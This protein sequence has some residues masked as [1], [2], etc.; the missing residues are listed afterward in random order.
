MRVRR[1]LTI[2]QMA[3][4]SG[5]ALVTICIFIVIQL[6]HFVQQRRDDYAQQLENVAQAVRQPLAEAVLRMDVPETKRVLNSLQPVGIL[7]RADIVLPNEFQA[8]H[9]NFPPE[10]PV[11]ALVAR[12][13]E[14][15]VQISVPLYSLERVPANPQPLAYLVLQADSY[16]M[17]Q[18]IL[19]TL[20]TMLSTYLLLA[21]IL[22]IAVS[23]C[24]NRLLVY[25]LRAMARELENVPQ[26]DLPYHQLMLPAQH[27]DDELGL[28]V[29]NYNRNQQTLAKAHT[30][31]SRLSTHNSMTE[32]PNPVLF[33]ALLEQH[34]AASMRPARFNLLVVGIE[35]LHEASGA[36]NPS[37]REA[38]LLTLAKKLRQVI[39]VDCVLAQL[40]NAEFAILAKNIEQPLH[41]MQLARRVMAAI[42]A[43]LNLQQK[44][45]LRP[46]ASIG[47]AHYPNSGESAE[48]LLR[49]ATSAM[50]SAHREGK[51]QILFFEPCLTEKTQKRLTQESEILL[52]IEQRQFALFLQ[53]QWDMQTNQV[54]GAEALLRWQLPDGQIILP[55]DVIPLAEELDV[56]VPLGNWVLEESCRIL[57][58]WQSQGITLPLAVNI[59][60]IQL[61]HKD[62]VPQLKRLLDEHQIDPHKL[63]LEITETVRIHDLDGALEL[64]RELHDLGVSIAL[65]DFGMGYASLNYL[66]RL[67]SLPIDLI[68]IDKSFIDGLPEDDAM[69]RI[70]S[71]ISEVLHLPVM[72]EGV[73]TTAQR[74]WLLQHGIRTGQGFLFAKP[75]PRKEFEAQ[76]ASVAKA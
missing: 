49:S 27:Q 9:A 23:W 26:E 58:A 55:A 17:Y 75:L 51:N 20:S 68:K 56:I 50:M 12:I 11:P 35:T 30:A 28:L 25:P 7:T 46:S 72:A 19:S 62:F 57:A 39:G 73:E 52:A 16:R 34:I 67:K 63:L 2:K 14:L 60:P 69:V 22:S 70:V 47:I 54:T 5:V 24:M 43:P 59:S 45:P 37:M 13:F 64:L 29:R 36:L 41:A 65:D 15:P 32:L 42:N 1:S 74:D 71:S 53:P 44:M 66:N 40:S 48:Q 3:A 6:F 76:F 33:A 8:L 38:L 31:M 61:Q 4:V 10:R 21:L 18:F